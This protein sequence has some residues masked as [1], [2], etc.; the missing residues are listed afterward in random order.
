MSGKKDMWEFPSDQEKFVKDVVGSS[1]A[2]FLSVGQAMK[3]FRDKN[4]P[5]EQRSPVKLFQWAVLRALFTRAI[6]ESTQISEEIK[7]EAFLA[8]EKLASQVEIVFGD[9]TATP[10]VIKFPSEKS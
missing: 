3:E 9:P 10:G 8:G 6:A 2:G 5:R 1:A 4:Y 7:Q